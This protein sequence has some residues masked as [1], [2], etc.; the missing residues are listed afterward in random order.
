MWEGRDKRKLGA[1][2]L[3][4]ISLDQ[5]GMLAA[6]LTSLN[7]CPSV[8]QR[9]CSVDT[10]NV[11][12]ARLRLNEPPGFKGKRVRYGFSDLN[13]YIHP[14]YRYP[15]V[16]VSGFVAPF[17]LNVL[18]FALLGNKTCS[19]LSR[20]CHQWHEELLGVINISLPAQQ[21]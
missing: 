8:P 11:N 17:L 15:V 7:P 10:P 18:H 12:T 6:H 2:L 19:F 9:L 20:N 13:M 3:P 5:V 21:S 14:E 16:L 1:Q 4:G